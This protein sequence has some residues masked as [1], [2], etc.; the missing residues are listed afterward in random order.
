M[1]KLKGNFDKAS[2]LVEIL[3]EMSDIPNNEREDKEDK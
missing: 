2:E 1:R 3:V